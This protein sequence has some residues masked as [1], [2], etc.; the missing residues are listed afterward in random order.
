MKNGRIILL[1]AS[2]I[3]MTTRESHAQFKL[4]GEFRPRA[5]YSHGYKTP[6]LDNQKASLFVSQRTRLNLDF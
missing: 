1:V 5:E 6:A 3:W 4:C 2:M